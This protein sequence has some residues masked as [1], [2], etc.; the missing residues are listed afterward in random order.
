VQYQLFNAAGQAMGGLRTTT[1]PVRERIDLKGL[2]AGWY[3]LRITTE[4]RGLTKTF[5]KK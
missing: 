5:F 4:Q 2:P 1:A 3:L